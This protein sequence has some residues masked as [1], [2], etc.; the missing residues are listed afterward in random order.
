MPLRPNELEL[1]DAWQRGVFDRLLAH[2]LMQSSFR[3]QIIFLD[4]SSS[5][6]SLLQRQAHVDIVFQTPGAGTMSIEVKIVRWPGV[7]QGRPGPTHYR[8]MFLETWSC[9]VPPNDQR[10]WMTTSQADFLLWCQCSLNERSIDCWPFP[11]QQLRTWYRH[12]Y[13][14]LPQRRVE[15]IINGRALWTQGR[16]APIVKVC[17]DI[18]VEGFSVNENGLISDLFGTPILHFMRPHKGQAA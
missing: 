12:N 15:N 7:R 17:N 8:D 14:Q 9:T 13:Q 18:H 6:A 3:N 11:F 16:L 5:I 10:G 1:D 4:I 2:V